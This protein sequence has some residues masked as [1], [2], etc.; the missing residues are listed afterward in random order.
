MQ[1]QY[2]TQLKEFKVKKGVIKSMKNYTMSAISE[3]AD[4]YEVEQIDNR[5][6]RLRT[7]ANTTIFLTKPFK[8]ETSKYTVTIKKGNKW[9]ML[10][11]DV[12]HAIV[13]I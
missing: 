7:D 10:W 1:K 11:K 3:I 4:I 6:L 5:T 8:I 9:L 2:L 13:L 12:K